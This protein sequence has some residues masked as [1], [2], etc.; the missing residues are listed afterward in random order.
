MLRLPR[1]SNGFI[2]LD[3]IIYFVVVELGLQFDDIDRLNMDT[4][5]SLLAQKNEKQKDE[6]D[7]LAHVVAVGVNVGLNGGEIDLFGRKGSADETV[8]LADMT[9]DEAEA[10]ARQQEEELNKLFD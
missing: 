7:M 9:E 5:V 8:N 3:K 4:I 10:F 2:D 1:T 6:Y